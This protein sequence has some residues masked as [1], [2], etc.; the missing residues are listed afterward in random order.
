MEII[1]IL[2]VTMDQVMTKTVCFGYFFRFVTSAST[3]RLRNTFKYVFKALFGFF[4]F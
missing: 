4:N 1:L 2:K 3:L